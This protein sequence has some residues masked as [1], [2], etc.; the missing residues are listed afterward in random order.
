VDG[1]VVLYESAAIVK[2]IAL[3]AKSPL[4][5]TSSLKEE[6]LLDQALAV[7]AS[8]WDSNISPMIANLVFVP[9]MSGK[10]GN[11]E[12]IKDRQGR[13]ETKLGKYEIILGKQKYL[14]GDRLTIAD[15][16]HLGWGSYLT[17]QG[18]PYFQDTEKYP[19]L[20]R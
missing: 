1:D 15:I 4:A 8:S 18:F 14:A 2:Y 19:N 9:L 3:K 10:P 7:E 20:V 5:V 11:Q 17:P 6:A 16:K 13:L 12:L